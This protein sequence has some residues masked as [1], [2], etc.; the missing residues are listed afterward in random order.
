VQCIS[1]WRLEL[2]VEY[3]TSEFH[4]YISRYQ[5]SIY[6]NINMAPQLAWIGLGNMGR[7][8]ASLDNL[9]R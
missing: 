1:T 9:I 5:G 8:S 6:S 2:L 7:V 3:S 4:I